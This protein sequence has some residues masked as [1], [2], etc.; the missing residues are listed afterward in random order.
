[1]GTDRDACS[2]R[3]AI[4]ECSADANVAQMGG[5]QLQTKLGVWI[6]RCSLLDE[7]GFAIAA[8]TAQGY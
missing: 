8:P 5:G 1:M 7:M 3:Q 2:V 4:L 6:V